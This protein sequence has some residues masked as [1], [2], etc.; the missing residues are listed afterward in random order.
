MFPSR[1][2]NHLHVWNRRLRTVAATAWAGAAALLIC[3]A[4]WAASAIAAPQSPTA[5]FGGG[6]IIAGAHLT[7]TEPERVF[8]GSL[9]L[10]EAVAEAQ[11]RHNAKVVKAEAHQDGGKTVYELRL[12]SDDGRVWTIRV[13]AATGAEL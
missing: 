3:S 1:F 8:A 11:K 13:D 5:G 6:A 4:S 7:G 10:D 12:L 9:T 2:S